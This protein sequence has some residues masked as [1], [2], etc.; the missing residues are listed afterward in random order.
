MAVNNHTTH[1]NPFDIFIEGWGRM[2]G[3]WGINK[4]MAQIY[5]LLYVS[6]H[7]LSLEEMSDKLKTSRSNVSL[8]VRSLLDLGMARKVLIRGD[9]RDYYTA[10][11]DIIKVA[12]RLAAERKKRELDPAIEIVEKA[13]LAADA[14][15]A[16]HPAGN[17]ATAFCA[18]RLKT[19]LSLML[20]VEGVFDSFIDGA[21]RDNL[22]LEEIKTNN[23]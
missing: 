1:D 14:P 11:E 13:I 20:I 23:I 15:G 10:E 16:P 8:N 12:K 3:A 21:S 4:V 22:P 5:A 19:F 18:D 17:E 6:K 2:A 7:P 9:R